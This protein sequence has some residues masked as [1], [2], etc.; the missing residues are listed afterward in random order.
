MYVYAICLS[1]LVYM[2]ATT[3]V[4][5]SRATSSEHAFFYFQ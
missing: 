1:N 2:A 3:P 5:E 4:A